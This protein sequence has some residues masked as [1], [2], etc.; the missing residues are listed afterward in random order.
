MQTINSNC[1]KKSIGSLFRI[2]DIYWLRIRKAFLF[3]HRGIYLCRLR[4]QTLE[5]VQIAAPFLPSRQFWALLWPDTLGPC[6]SLLFQTSL[7]QI[8]LC[9][10]SDALNLHIPTFNICDCPHGFFRNLMFNEYVRIK[11]SQVAIRTQL[12][13]D[14]K[15]FRIDVFLTFF[16]NLWPLGR[17]TDLV[18]GLSQSQGLTDTLVSQWGPRFWMVLMYYCDVRL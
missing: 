8:S 10:S 17:K 12:A 11:G 4:A 14:S 16:N 13:L 9:P 1:T 18:V 7:L 3:N 15:L 2:W 5:H 6:L